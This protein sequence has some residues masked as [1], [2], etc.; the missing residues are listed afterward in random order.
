MFEEL[1]AIDEGMGI[2]GCTGV[3]MG[4]S[5]GPGNIRMY[6]CKVDVDSSTGD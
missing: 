6:G 5:L 2:T 4:Y 1:S 3:I